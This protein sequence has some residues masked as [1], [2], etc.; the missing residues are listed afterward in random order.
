MGQCRFKCITSVA[1]QV[2]KQIKT[3]KELVLPLRQSDKINNKSKRA[4]PVP[5]VPVNTDNGYSSSAT[6]ST[7]GA[8]SP[9]HPSGST[10]PKSREQ[11]QDSDVT[12]DYGDP[13]QSDSATH[14]EGTA[15]PT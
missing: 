7:R 5:A 10:L 8:D 13:D 12:D 15:E 9:N 3:K 2:I 1:L 6:P 14:Q 11:D 4:A